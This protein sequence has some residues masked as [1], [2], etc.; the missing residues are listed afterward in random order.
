MTLF[1]AALLVLCITTFTTGAAVRET[2]G[3]RMAKGLGPLPPRWMP[4]R[5]K[6]S[7]TANRPSASPSPSIALCRADGVPLCCTSAVPPSDPTAASLIKLL[8]A[9]TPNSDSGLVAITCSHLSSRT[10]ARQ[11][12]CCDSDTF[13]GVIATGCTMAR[14]R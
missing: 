10:C 4:T 2:N 3:Q 5:T 9:T 14:R 13:D 12:V 1:F 7:D 11:T 6:G 8:G